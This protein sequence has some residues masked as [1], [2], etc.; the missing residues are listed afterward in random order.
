[1]A[2]KPQTN[3]SATDFCSNVKAKPPWNKTF[4]WITSKA[5]LEYSHNASLHRHHKYACSNL[6]SKRARLTRDK[7][8][9][10]P[11]FEFTRVRPKYG[12]ALL[13]QYT[14]FRNLNVSWN[15]LELQKTWNRRQ[16]IREPMH[17]DN[18]RKAITVLFSFGSTRVYSIGYRRIERKQT[19]CP[20]ED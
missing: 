9:V 11:V 6:V 18:L 17:A 8:H 15:L 7:A 2:N 19:I 3:C 1:M 20:T 4:A 16:H 14:T 5:K 12:K 10:F 13:M